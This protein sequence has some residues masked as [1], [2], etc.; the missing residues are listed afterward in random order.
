MS[1]RP[2]STTQ[3]LLASMML[4]RPAYAQQDMVGPAW[5][6]LLL[7]S[8]RLVIYAIGEVALFLA[9]PLALL[10]IVSWVVSRRG[11]GIGSRTPSTLVL[12]VL[13]VL[14]AVPALIYWA[15]APETS[16]DP[17]KSYRSTTVKDRKV[18]PLAPP[19]GTSWP[20]DTGYLDL[21]QGVQGGHGVISVSGRSS[22]QRV[23]VKL[24]E[25]GERLCPGLRHAFVQRY[26]AFEFRNLP[27]GAYEVR[28]LPI[29]RPTIGGRSQPI[30]ISEH[31]EDVHVVKITDS[32]VLDSNYP[33]VGIYPKDF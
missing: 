6:Q 24:C 4:A 22:F 17:F 14:T 25:A 20:R 21:P 29:D 1:N 33:V 28:Y 10:A 26:S 23:Y 5:L 16:S 2:H 19:A 15:N 7:A 27:A 18:R 8:P 31:A 30:T 9:P 11:G 12:A 13:T 3:I 32:P